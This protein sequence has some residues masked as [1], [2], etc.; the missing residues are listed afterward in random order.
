M[1][2]EKHRDTERTARATDETEALGTPKKGDTI[3]CDECGMELEV[4]VDCGGADPDAVQ[5][6]CCG[7]EMRRI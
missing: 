3:R 4:T 1:A 2:R 6:Q 5:F 7:Q